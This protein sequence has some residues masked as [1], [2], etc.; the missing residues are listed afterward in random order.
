[1]RVF[2]SWSGARSEALGLALKDWLPKV[3]PAVETFHSADIP[4]GKNWHSALI[5]ELRGCRVGVFCV[6]PESLRSPW[7]LFE[8]G[9][10]AQHGSQPELFTYLYGI[11]DGRVSGPLAPFQA[12]RFDREDSRRL[13]H[14]LARLVDKDAAQPGSDFDD[15]WNELEAN[16]LPRL[17]L[18]I[19]RLIPEFPDLFA[20]KK[21][22]H[23]SFPDCSDQRWD[24]RL[25][26]TAR[27]HETL[28]RPDIADIVASDPYLS[29][30]FEELLAALDRYD[31]HI[32]AFLMEPLEY[33]D[34]DEKKQRLLED[35]RT[36]VLNLVTALERHREPPVFRESLTFEAEPSAETRKAL[37]HK[38]E[39]RLA[40]IQGATL[41]AARNSLDW[42]L[43]RIVFYAA[44]SA[45]LLPNVPLSD[46]VSALKR[47]EEQA[48][49]RNLVKGLQPV[50]YA[51]E[52]IDE[53]LTPPLD[54]DTAERLSEVLETLDRFLQTDA[55]RDDGG[56]IRRRLTSIRR[57][58]LGSQL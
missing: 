48:R 47:E 1:M 52:A 56:H 12:T 29:G 42:S 44:S 10:L 38:L 34:L 51:A 43:D 31:M 16:L 22:F 4:K 49:A 30:A 8:A 54:A 24:D 28:S 35:S 26:R 20:L 36:H 18:P 9:A 21:T 2:I 58:V 57:K 19:Q 5:E 45:G 50:Y 27:V 3:L 11:P 55:R 14:D 41:L 33:T 32:G 53:R 37:I 46:L 7:M 17:L 40:K 6:T 25:R 23:E 39:L 13:V 15:R